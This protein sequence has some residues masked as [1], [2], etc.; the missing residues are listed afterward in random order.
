MMLKDINIDPK[1]KYGKTVSL[2]VPDNRDGK[3]WRKIYE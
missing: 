3:F 2:V 1:Y